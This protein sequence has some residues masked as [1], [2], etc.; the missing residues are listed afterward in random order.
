MY[1]KFFSVP[2]YI[3]GPVTEEEKSYIS[4]M[5]YIIEN[6]SLLGNESH[7]CSELKH[8]VT[9]IE[10]GV[11]KATGRRRRHDSDTIYFSMRHS[12]ETLR[13][14]AK[15]D[16]CINC[17][18]HFANL[19]LDCEAIGDES[20]VEQISKQLKNVRPLNFFSSK[21]SPPTIEWDNFKYT[22]Q[23]KDMEHSFWYMHYYCPILGYHELVFPIHFNNKII[24]VLFVGQIVIKVS[25]DETEHSDGFWTVAH[26]KDI[27]DDFFS[28][29]ATSGIFEEFIHH[30]DNIPFTNTNG[31][32]STDKNEL[33]EKILDHIKNHKQYEKSHRFFVNVFEEEK[34]KIN[35]LHD[36]DITVDECKKLVKDAAESVFEFQNHLTSKWLEKQKDY[37][38]SPMNGI[39][40]K[41]FDML[42]SGINIGIETIE[43]IVHK[44]SLQLDE[45]RSNFSF[46]R[47][48]I[49]GKKIRPSLMQDEGLHY[50]AG[51]DS[52]PCD[53]IL[54]YLNKK[55][56]NDGGQAFPKC[57]INF[58]TDL[59][60][61]F[62]EHEKIENL[63]NK[64]L[65]VYPSWVVMLDVEN[66]D[67]YKA[68]YNKF[69]EL[70]EP[71]FAR[72]F[73]ALD[74][75]TAT[76]ASEKLL[77][78]L[79]MYRHESEKIA[80][81]ITIKVDKLSKYSFLADDC[82]DIGSS[83][84]LV[85]NLEAI[86]SIVLGVHRLE[87]S[88][89]KKESIKVYKQLLYKWNN[90]FSLRLN[91]DNKNIVVPQPKDFDED[92][93]ELIHTYLQLLELMVYNLVDNAVKYSYWGTKI[94][95][96]F[97]SYFVDSSVFVIE[98]ENYGQKIPLGEEPY[99]TFWRAGYDD[100]KIRGEG[101]GLFF[102]K[103]LAKTLDWNVY[104]KCDFVSDKNIGLFSQYLE[105]DLAR[106]PKNKDL[107]NLI[108]RESA[109]ISKKHDTSRMI[110]R[111][112]NKKI[113]TLAELEDEINRETWHTTFYIE[114]VKR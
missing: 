103:Q 30:P 93:P 69:V 38:R 73:T 11:D 54:V 85:K 14:C 35:P 25:Q 18:N 81:S 94:H 13:I 88:P 19:L 67:G 34:N 52:I 17:D 66:L 106:D 75:I 113:S 20:Q 31:E 86:T 82:E 4:K 63:K 77:S 114:G 53:K 55:T 44:F 111:H 12:C 27:F 49:Y 70:L 45:I 43:Q 108:Q 37:V 112:T 97:S 24:G 100:N 36:T 91:A 99:N 90:A 72:F 9:I 41:F 16:M 102:V 61:G 58:K 8:S 40:T 107:V 1:N 26:N 71:Y 21:W 59:F 46:N 48:S 74:A 3:S 92:V 87:E 33:L 84:L 78:M 5:D 110:N 15:S 109:L 28:S 101:L 7:I 62:Y 83:V 104:H 60:Q 76:W 80:E 23:G 64:I 10:K 95:I 56:L 47:I 22:E 51:S 32:Q 79:R 68:E 6:R 39:A 105:S 98:V 42:P 29:L 89:L 65:L 57:S 50:Y 2:T 96:K